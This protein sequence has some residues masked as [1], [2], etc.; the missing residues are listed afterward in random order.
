MNNALITLA[1]LGLAMQAAQ[2]GAQAKIIELTQTPCQFLQ[3]EGG[4]DHGFKSAKSADC[5]AINRRTGEQRLKA[6]KTLELKPG[7]YVFRVKNA[8]VP[9]ELGF[10]LRGDSLLERARLPSVSGGGLT[11]GKTQDYAIELKP[12]NYVYSCPL[13][14][15]PDYKLV[16]R[17]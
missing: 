7:K 10:W 16:V 5:E 3:S 14:P 17:S 1:G 11:T 9:Y 4:K 8:N 2:A 15:T 12:G 6:A 13:N